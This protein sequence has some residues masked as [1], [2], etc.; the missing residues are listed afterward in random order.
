MLNGHGN[1]IFKYSDIIA[2]FSSNV[3][4][5]EYNKRL[6]DKLKFEGFNINCLTNYPEPDAGGCSKLFEERYNLPSDSVLTLNGSVEGIYL[7]AETYKKSKALIFISSFREYEDASKKFKHK[8][9][10]QA[11]DIFE[12]GGSYDL[13]FLCNPNNPDGK[14]YPT[15][16]IEYF[17]SKYPD[18]IFVV[19]EAYIEFT[20]ASESFIRTSKK[21]KNLIILRSFT[22]YY[23]IP[24]VRLGFLI[25]HP[26]VV[27]KIKSNKIPWSVN[28]IAVSFGKTILENFKELAPDLTELFGNSE[29]LKRELIQI[30]NLKIYPSNTP[31]FLIKSK[32]LKA[33]K[34][35]NILAEKYKILIRDASNFRGLTDYYFRIS[36]QTAEK[37]LMLLNALK[38]IYA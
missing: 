15:Y 14:I 13:V 35:K 26:E 4:P 8:I 23:S 19:D 38:G 2:D 34:L 1:D 7:I 3:V 9:T 32:I 24:G 16:K 10:Y 29:K 18:T 21:Y 12:I 31:F 25:G 36:T 30:D 5:Y 33:E 22:K 6:L 27:S 11:N 17:L 28:S 37:N 20:P